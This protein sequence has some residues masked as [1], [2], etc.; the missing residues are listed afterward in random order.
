MLCLVDRSR[1]NPGR[2]W[3][4]WRDRDHRHYL[5][6]YYPLPHSPEIGDAVLRIGNHLDMV[7]I[8]QY[9]P[10]PR[11]MMIERHVEFSSHLRRISL[12]RYDWI[13]TNPDLAFTEAM[14][15]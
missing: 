6:I 14:L 5:V 3:A 9:E 12:A 13:E 4:H 2:F 11:P 8:E 7:P 1:A 10:E 15:A